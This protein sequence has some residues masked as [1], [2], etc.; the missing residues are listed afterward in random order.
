M[1]ASKIVRLNLQR[2][3]A[4][5]TTMRAGD[6]SQA[7]LRGH[8]EVEVLVLARSLRAFSTSQITKKQ[9][10]LPWTLLRHTVLGNRKIR[11]YLL[12]AG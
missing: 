4:T 7:C 8:R 5:A 11:G 12:S 1:F 2:Y 3:T 6:V 9:Q 10:S